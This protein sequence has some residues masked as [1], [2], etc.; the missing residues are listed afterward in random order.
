MH[1]DMNTLLQ[2][3]CIACWSIFTHNHVYTYVGMEN[4]AY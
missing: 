4:M 2:C 1:R 3:M